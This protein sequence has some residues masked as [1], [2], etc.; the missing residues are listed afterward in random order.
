MSRFKR[1][2]TSKTVSP[3]DL[4][5]AY[6]A[7]HDCVHKGFRSVGGKVDRLT[8]TVQTDRHD[9]R[10]RDVRQNLQL[11]HLAGALGVRLPSDEEIKEGVRPQKAKK[12]LAGV[13]PW[14]AASA[15]FGAAT[16]AAALYKYVFPALEA[17]AAA[18]HAA[19]MAG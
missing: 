3:E 7:L 6:N 1:L 17:G 12:K 11:D 4:A 2:D 16:G 19:L 15:L 13:A 14:Q 18:L 9:A 10:N 5:E 8:K